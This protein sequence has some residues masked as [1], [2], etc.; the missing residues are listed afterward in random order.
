ME[1]NRSKEKRKP[2]RRSKGS[3][4][5]LSVE[6]Q[7][8]E[9]IKNLNVCLPKITKR[10][11]I[12]DST[13]ESSEQQTSPEPIDAAPNSSNIEIKGENETSASSPT[14]CIDTREEFFIESIEDGV[15]RDTQLE[16][17]EDRVIEESRCPAI[18]KNRMVVSEVKCER[19]QLKEYKESLER[20]KRKVN[21]EMGELSLNIMGHL[22]RSEVKIKSVLLEQELERE[23]ERK[24]AIQEEAPPELKSKNKFRPLLKKL[25]RSE[26]EVDE[27]WVPSV[28][29]KVLPRKM[30][31]RSE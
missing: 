21:R 23:R 30:E 7:Y 10:A 19:F 4:E 16:E 13:N 29:H 3:V 20:F 8:R 1:V 9:L 6:K 5:H 31:C 25:S 11:K 14:Q 2:K 26:D 17:E 28:F 24:R 15:F 18:H 27:N 22:N 12:N